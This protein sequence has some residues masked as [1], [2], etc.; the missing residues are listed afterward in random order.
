M[1]AKLQ[2]GVIYIFVDKALLGNWVSEWGKFVDPTY[3]LIKQMEFVMCHRSIF[4]SMDTQKFDKKFDKWKDGNHHEAF[5]L[6]KH[7]LKTWLELSI[8][9]QSGKIT[10]AD[11]KDLL[12]FENCEVHLRHSLSK[13][14]LKG[15]LQRITI[16]NI[17]IAR[18]FCDEC[19]LSFS[20]SS[21]IVC[22]LD[23]LKA[24]C[25]P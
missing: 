16:H 12:I 18:T 6:P 5:I 23:K 4:K 3:A 14:R 2:P 13:T 15:Q 21:P 24:C 22:I 1:L 11:K 9:W 17:P 8:I 20:D 19:Y 7:H 25:N 10:L